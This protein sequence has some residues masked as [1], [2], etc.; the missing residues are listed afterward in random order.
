MVNNYD[1]IARYYDVLSRAVFR[2]SQIIAQVNQL[3]FIKENTA[4]LIVG[5]GTGWILDEISKLNLTGLSITYVE[6]SSKMVA[7][8][9]KRIHSN[10]QIE[11]I[12]IGIEEFAAVSNFDLI[13]TPFVF[14]NFSRQRAEMV[15]DKLDSLLN[16]NGYWFLTDFTTQGK[17]AN[18]WKKI[19]LK[20]MY[21]FFKMISNVEAKTL[22]DVYPIFSKSGYTILEERFYYSQFIKATVFKK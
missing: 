9:K 19:F 18:W 16:K 14:D 22:V 2:Q 17:N 4:I 12:N 7:L 11:F 10:N 21:T 8:S 20:L 1:K 5:G 3:K 13:L 6:I 15:F